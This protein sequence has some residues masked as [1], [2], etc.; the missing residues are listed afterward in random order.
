MRRAISQQMSF[1]DGFIDASLYKLDEE[2]KKVD[3]LLSDAQLLNPFE[4]A[5]DPSLGRPGTAVGVYLRMMYLKFRWGLSYE[6]VEREVRERLPWRY[7]CRLSLMDPV[8]D[9]T[10]L[11]K[12]NQRFGEDR[13]SA[14]NKHLVKQLLKTRLIKPRRIRIDSTTLEA[15][16][17]YPNDVGVIHQ[18]VKSLTRTAASLGSKITS[19]VRAT[20]RALFSWSQTAK[21]NPKERKEKGRKI[22]NKVAKLAKHTIEQSDKAF[23]SLKDSAS[24]DSAK[25]K[26]KFFQ[27]IELAETILSQT[28][29][30]LQGQKSIPER[31]VSFH[32]PQ[33]RPIRKGKLNKM[34]EFGRTLQ[35]MQ[36]RS[37]VIVHYEIHRGH[38][39]DSTELLSLVR[40]AK[41]R[42]G[43]KPTELAADR[44]YYS[45]ENLE[46]LGRAGF[47][48]IGIPK[49]GRLS[50][51]EK[52][53][54]RKTWF[55]QLQR[56]RCGIEGSIS[57]LK[58][59]FGLGRVLA[60]GSAG[61]AVW[62]GL[63]I[64]AYNL[65]QRT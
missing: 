39:N 30:K 53:H 37:G 59:K 10:T 11:I 23:Q 22:L 43:I 28:E 25:L 40:K 62:T 50:K 55:R 17:S 2:L 49:L 8:P 60:K 52:M 12:L 6:E 4:E 64:F 15:H 20:K 61:T 42:L 65:W 29:H 51:T 46:K 18:A 58:R 7:F 44:G 24:N 32:D 9:A 14:L 36:D 35:L 34:V 33:V 45:A 48:K 57:M 5:F 56:F 13:I 27:Q 63:A 19:H 41:T 26:Q 54:Q 47:K 21:A 1:G 38:P 16:I 3:E 31:I